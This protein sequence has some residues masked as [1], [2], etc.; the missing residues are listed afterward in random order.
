[1]KG[2]CTIISKANADIQGSLSRIS[3]RQDN[4]DLANNAVNKKLDQMSET[5][6]ETKTLLFSIQNQFQQHTAAQKKTTDKSFQSL[7]EVYSELAIHKSILSNR[8][9]TITNLN[10]Q[11]QTLQNNLKG[12]HLDIAKKED[13]LKEFRLRPSSPTTSSANKSNDP[14]IT[15]NTNKK[16]ASSSQDASADTSNVTNTVPINITNEPND[17]SNADNANKTPAPSLR[18]SSADA[19]NIIV[20]L[21]DTSNDAKNTIT[22]IS[23][24]LEVTNTNTDLQ[25][26]PTTYNTSVSV[27]APAKAFQSNTNMNPQADPTTNNTSDPP[28]TSADSTFNNTNTENGPATRPSAIHNETSLLYGL[29]VALNDINVEIIKSR[30]A[31][32]NLSTTGRKQELVDRL[33]DHLNQH[34]NPPTPII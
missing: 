31:D 19:R 33:R 20:S 5:I 7:Q 30:L 6:N 17:L 16:P 14:S 24:V 1:V 21:L 34:P 3:K 23:K 32:K 29:S 9:A 27:Q 26:D 18:D 11:I 2:L 4:S 25:A 12:S 10:S 15:D 28:Q 13:L 8:E 22:T